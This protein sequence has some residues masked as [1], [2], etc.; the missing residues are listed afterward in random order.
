MR[1]VVVQRKE[2]CGEDYTRRCFRELVQGAYWPRVPRVSCHPRQQCDSCI[3]SNALA[4]RPH[5]ASDCCPQALVSDSGDDVL[6]FFCGR[7]GI[8][9]VL[10]SRACFSI[11]APLYVDYHAQPLT[12][13]RV[14]CVRNALC[15]VVC[16]AMG[17]CVC[18]GVCV[19]LAC[20]LLDARGWT[21]ALSILSMTLL[22]C[23][24]ML[25]PA[26][27]VRFV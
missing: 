26:T 10:A 23:P 27:A 6:F 25:S 19:T 18:A 9:S 12:A 17:V 11:H 24:P 4:P 20:L 22:P 3:Q 16:S 21:Q 1:H 7:G 14:A 5:R 15:G 8:L 13:A 2:Q